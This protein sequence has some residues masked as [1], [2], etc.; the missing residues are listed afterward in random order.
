[1]DCWNWRLLLEIIFSRFCVRCGKLDTNHLSRNPGKKHSITSMG[2]IRNNLI[3]SS[4]IWSNNAFQDGNQW[5]LPPGTFWTIDYCSVDI[6]A[7]SCVWF[8]ADWF[9][10]CSPLMAFFSIMALTLC[11]G[12]P[13]QGMWWT[14]PPHV[15]PER[16]PMS[17]CFLRGLQILNHDYT[18]VP[19]PLPLRVI[20]RRPIF[21]IEIPTWLR[22]FA[23]ANCKGHLKS[24]KNKLLAKLWCSSH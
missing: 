23:L 7:C 14:C 10:R 21:S 19:P 2:M 20:N 9:G 24:F 13:S 6:I 15:S 12:A 5:P 4:S 17:R 22:G 18:V 8:L 1:M 16:A 3:R 11:N